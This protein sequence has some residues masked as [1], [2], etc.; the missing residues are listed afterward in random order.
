[1]REYLSHGMGVDSTALMLLLLDEGREF[2]S[3]FVNHG[4][5]YPETYEYLEYLKNEGYDIMV[6]KPSVIAKIV[7]YDNI[8]DYFWHYKGIPLQRYRICTDKFKIRPFNKYVE[9]PCV[10]YLGYDFSER[11]RSYKL[12]TRTKKSMKYEFPLI[13]KR[14][15]REQCKDIIREHGLKVPRKSGCW[16]CPF[17]SKKQW[18]KLMVEYPELFKKAMDLEERALKHRGKIG[19]LNNGKSKLSFFWQENKLTN[20]LEKNEK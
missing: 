6:I 4:C 15:T 8:Y 20:Y 13:D 16:L 5:D 10:V 19:L 2:E 12:F 17:Q 7:R 9:I 11:K 14:I 18:K 1:M 3:V